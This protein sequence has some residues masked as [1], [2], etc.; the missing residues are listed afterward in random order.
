MK[1][2]RLKKR[3]LLIISA[4]ILV[5]AVMV[6]KSFQHSGRS[7]S[8]DESDEIIPLGVEFDLTRYDGIS[9][10]RRI[11]YR[12]FENIRWT[13]DAYDHRLILGNAKFKSSREKT[14]TLCEV[15]SMIELVFQ[16]E[17]IAIAGDAPKLIVRT[18]CKAQPG[19][20]FLDPIRI[21]WKKIKA[22]PTGTK[23]F[24]DTEVTLI[25]RSLD[26]FW[27]LE[28]SLFELRLYPPDGS[29]SFLTTGYDVIAIHGEPL[30]FFLA[31][32][33]KWQ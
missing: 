1:K 20:E 8:S 12:L 14:S 10:S 28:W 15:Y 2:F 19:S 18:S 25:F 33:D 30:N 21:P 29:A 16:A 11:K 22:L 27:P 7:I 13:S 4:V 17:G 31:P 6:L 26:D 5:T 24:R 32:L 3:A 9:L 23:T